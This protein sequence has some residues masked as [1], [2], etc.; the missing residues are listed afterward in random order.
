MI[1]TTLVLALALAGLAA[2]PAPAADPLPDLLTGRVDPLTYDYG[3]LRERPDADAWLEK[4]EATARRFAL[5]RLGVPD[6]VESDDAT[7]AGC[8]TAAELA[9]MRGLASARK[10][11]T[12]AE[13][14]AARLQ[15]DDI[16]A[17]R[18]SVRRVIFAGEAGPYEQLRGVE[19]A[20]RLSREAKDPAVAE[21]F[22]RNAEDQF[23]R[24][25]I[26]FSARLFLAE[27]ASEAAL[28]LYDAPIIRETCLIDAANRAWLKGT[29]ETRGWFRISADGARAD[30]AAWNMVQHA[31]KDVAFQRSMLVLLEKELAAKET[32]P[33]NYAYL[34]DRVAVN[35]GQPQRYATQ[36]RCEGPGDWRPRTLEDPANVEKRRT[37]MGIDWP[38]AEYTAKMNTFCR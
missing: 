23:S 11:K 13:W 15:A 36:G 19:R 6:A 16:E 12:R 22:R 2:A 5:R 8:E 38:M 31:D 21:L 27:G 29:I 1:R 32:S 14:R 33:G 10:V 34:W 17:R 7:Y 30:S 3:A 28:D 25:S 26:G 35:T 20:I 24:L 9:L 37:E 4:A 18:Q